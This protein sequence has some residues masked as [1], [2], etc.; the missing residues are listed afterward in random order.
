MGYY[1]DLKKIGIDEYKEIL[2]TADLLPSRTVLKENIDD[3]FDAIK[4]D[5]TKFLERSTKAGFSFLKPA[6]ALQARYFQRNLFLTICLE[7]L[8]PKRLRMWRNYE[9]H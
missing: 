6:L 2:R 7:S 3:I 5:P 8:R 9:Q 1:I 4:V